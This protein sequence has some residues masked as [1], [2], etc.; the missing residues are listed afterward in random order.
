MGQWYGLV[1]AYKAREVTY[2]SDKLRA[3][4]GLI[5]ELALL[6]INGL[7]EEET[8]ACSCS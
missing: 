1:E 8:G 5:K 7:W 2:E 4:A 3:V 6:Q